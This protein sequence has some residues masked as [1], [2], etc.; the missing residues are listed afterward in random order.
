[1]RFLSLLSAV[2]LTACSGAPTDHDLTISASAVGV[3]GEILERQLAEFERRT[4]AR[5]RIQR[6]PDDATQRHQL[7]VQWLN[8]RIGTPD[9]L[10]IDVVWT[11]EFA[12]AGWIAPIGERFE[13]DD[14]A[15]ATIEANRW[16]GE[17]YAVP[18]FVDVGML[19]RRTDLVPEAPATL[20]DLLAAATSR[21]E[22][23]AS[24][25]VWQ[26]ARYEGLVTVYLEILSG[27]G[28]AILDGAGRPI[29]SAPSG[30]AALEW[31]Q[32]A[33]ED[34]ASPRAVLTWH[35]EETRF[36]F[37]NGRALFM[38]NWP[39]AAP[40]LEDP[41]E[42]VVAS[43]FAISPMPPIRPGLAPAATL[44][45]AQ[46]A[47]NRWSSNQRLAREL[48]AFLTAP[49]QMIDRARTTGQYPARLGLYGSGDLDRALGLES[50]AVKRI[51]ESAVPR[52]STPVYAEI[53]EILQIELH[54]AL[55]AGIDASDALRA[56]D[57]AI[58]EILSSSGLSAE[59][60]R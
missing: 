42:S 9:V 44:G 57:Q 6:T 59:E 50:A 16:R 22:G 20:G 35:E 14:F 54:R 56:A 36:A 3:E 37:Q 40:L 31:L 51:I 26:G 17:T 46:L 58:E 8:A 39:Y 33:L 49:A 53:S 34:G 28:G 7:Y 5:V 12:A 2:L 21:P 60:D 32:R 38:R 15:P 25:F 4:G 23:I 48:I 41:V 47:I 24:G 18:W 27:H 11:P 19:Y 30:V 1:M 10:Q 29:L 55:T 52:P 13:L 43:R 45:G